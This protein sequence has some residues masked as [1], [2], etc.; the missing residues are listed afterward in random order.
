MIRLAL[1]RAPICGNRRIVAIERSQ[2]EA[3]IV[4]EFGFRRVQDRG[5]L[6]QLQGLRMTTSLVVHDAEIVKRQ[7]MLAFERQCGAIGPLGTVEIAT[8]VNR[9]SLLRERARRGSRL[10]DPFRR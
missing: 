7:R 1:E 6:E 10:R 3:C 5:A 9:E 8:L 2:H 4:V